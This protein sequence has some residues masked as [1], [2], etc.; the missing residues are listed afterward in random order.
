M[1]QRKPYVIHQEPGKVRITNRDKLRVDLL[2]GF[3]I[4]DILELKKFNFIYL[5]K[6]YETKGLLNGEI[7][8]MKVR[9]IQV[10]KQ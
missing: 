6:G 3:K 4:S 5:T 1:K 2:D 10:F 8:D 7:V 9:Y